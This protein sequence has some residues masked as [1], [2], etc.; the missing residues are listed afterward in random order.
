MCVV[1][2]AWNNPPNKPIPVSRL[3]IYKVPIACIEENSKAIKAILL[4]NID[5]SRLKVTALE[6]II[7][8]IEYMII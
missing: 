7:K 4:Y 1:L 2:V 5:L 6:K 8:I 3:L